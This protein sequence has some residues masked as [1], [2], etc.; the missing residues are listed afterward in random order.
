MTVSSF[1]NAE[2][3]IEDE[4]GFPCRAEFRGPGLANRLQTAIFGDLAGIC[5]TRIKQQQTAAAEFG[6]FL[7]SRLDQEMRQNP[8]RID[9][10]QTVSALNLRSH[11]ISTFN[12]YDRRIDRR[13]SKD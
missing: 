9:S 8:T 13:T 2:K 11:S 10:H 7:L 3:T 1:L 4:C 6:T 5:K 12:R